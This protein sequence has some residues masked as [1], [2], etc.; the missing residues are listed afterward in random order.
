MSDGLQRDF[1]IHTGG[2]C[3]GLCDVLSHLHD[4]L[5]GVH[6]E[7][8]DDP[9]GEAWCVP[10]GQ[11]PGSCPRKAEPTVDCCPSQ[12]YCSWAR[13]APKRTSR[14]P[15]ARPPRRLLCRRKPNSPA[16]PP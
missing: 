9:C 2:G 15:P 5:P 12:R 7:W 6:V 8:I 4:R 13:A 11:C 16:I 14:P 1:M 10:F 3:V